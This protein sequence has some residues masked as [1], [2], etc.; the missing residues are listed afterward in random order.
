MNVT[1]TGIKN[2]AVTSYS[3]K[4]KKTGSGHI[5][6]KLD[7]EF[8]QD[9]TN[10]QPVLKRCPS[11]DGQHG[12]LEV[13]IFE[14]YTDINSNKDESDFTYKSSFNNEDDEDMLDDDDSYG[15]SERRIFINGKEIKV[16]DG[17]L[18][19][20]IK[21]A[22]LFEKMSQWSL[23]EIVEPESDEKIFELK[24][25]LASKNP[26]KKHAKEQEYLTDLCDP[27]VIKRTTAD[28]SFDI[29][30]EV[31][32]YLQSSPCFEMEM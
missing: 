20:L 13:D 30:D 2:I 16:N 15:V 29:M 25:I 23:K 32:Q 4:E 8:H 31:V 11:K 21:V 17:Q 10:L 19:I 18:P 26:N 7:D 5:V 14:K 3:S 6:L 24:N 1:F 27:E 22:R 12:L 9:L 28:M